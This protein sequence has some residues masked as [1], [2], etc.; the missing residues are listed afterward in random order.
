MKV[1]FPV[2]ILLPQDITQS[3]PSTFSLTPPNNGLFPPRRKVLRPLKFVPRRHVRSRRSPSYRIHLPVSPLGVFRY[4]SIFFFAQFP[5]PLLSSFR[6]LAHRIVPRRTRSNIPRK[7][8]VFSLNW[9][10][11]RSLA[12]PQS[13]PGFSS[14]YHFSPLLFFRPSSSP[15]FS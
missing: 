12:P 11:R 13:P 8:A 5:P 3:V 1:P 6:L 2:P 9:E 15:D 14:V 10:L 7:F 4:S